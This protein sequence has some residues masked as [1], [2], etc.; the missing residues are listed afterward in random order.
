MTKNTFAIFGILAVLLLSLGMVSSTN[1]STFSITD[2]ST[3]SSVAEDAGSFTFTFN[4]TYTSTSQDMDFSFDD[5]FSTIGTVTISN[6]TGL[7]GTI[8]ESRI[9]TG[10]VTGFANQGGNSLTVYINATSRTEYRDD[11]SSFTVSIT[12]APA[13]SPTSNTLC[14][15]EGYDEDGDLEISDFDINN[16]GEGS[17]DEWQ[18]LDQIEIEVEIE[19]TNNDDD[20]EDVEVMIVIFDDKIEDSGSDVTNDFDI[21]DEI[22]TGIGR[23]R[24]GDQETVTFT[25]DEVPADLEDGT[26]YMYIM[27]YE[28]G[29]ED[30]QCISEIDSTDYY[31]QFTVESVDYDE[32]IVVRGAELETQ[33][34]TYCDH[35]NL[36]ISIPIYN[37]GEDEEEKIL[38]NLYNSELGIDKYATIDDLDNGDKEVL[39]FFVDIPSELTKERYDLDIIV[40]FDWDD[41]EDDNDPL[42]YDEEISETSIRLNILSCAIAAPSITASLES[43]TEIGQNLIVKTTITNNG[44][45]NDFVIAPM[46]FESWA[47]LVSVTPGTATIA[48]G[49]SQEVIIT[50]SPKESGAQTFR[51]STIVDGETYN[52]PVSVRIAEEPGMFS[53]LGLS[54]L[55]LYLAV[56]IG[57]LLVLVLLALIVRVARR[58][59]K[60]AEF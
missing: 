37:L 9:V 26:Y 52:Q 47:N 29:N 24:D 56:G 45:T 28:D 2:I 6:E 49:D 33:I 40:S 27:V 48:S 36:E 59:T 50:L 19:N 60:S 57:I 30:E 44:D 42:S 13:P 54:G 31:F 39:T 51:I 17:D 3:Q 41:E 11:E 46:G 10:T 1:S 5:S 53:G 21:S 15:L 8:D 38:V 20:V 16:N 32:S 34:N 22:L 7:D 43:S 18:Y 55:P 4:L 25:I 14:E 12:D 58:P 35:K 23:L